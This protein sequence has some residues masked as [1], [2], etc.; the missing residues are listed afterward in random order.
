MIDLSTEYLGLRLKSPLIASSS[1]LWKDL[2]NLH[3]LEEA[4]RRHLEYIATHRLRREQEHARG[5]RDPRCLLAG[6]S[7]NQGDV[8]ACDQGTRLIAHRATN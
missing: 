1:P 7:G 4:G 6:A 5:I 2:A 8:R 3:A